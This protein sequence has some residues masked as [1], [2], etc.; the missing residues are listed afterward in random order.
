MTAFPSPRL[1]AFALVSLAAFLSSVGC[2]TSGSSDRGPSMAADTRMPPPERSRGGD[3]PAV[4]ASGRPDGGVDRQRTPAGAGRYTLA[5]PTGDRA[6]SVI[7]LEAAGPEEV[8]LGQPYTYQLKVTN[9]TDT[10]LHDVE[11]LKLPMALTGTRPG[12]PAPRT[13]EPIASD[14]ATTRPA[15][16][17][18]A[19]L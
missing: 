5:Y 1:R 13:G 7:L 3:S 11:I 17:G 18:D 10:P 16:A 8:R 14:R 9:L 2:Q 19:R 15:D 4:R 6:T 12:T